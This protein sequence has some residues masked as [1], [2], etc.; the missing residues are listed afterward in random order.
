[1]KKYLLLVAAILA[2]F[3]SPAAAT[4]ISF[5]APSV[6]SGPFDVIVRAENLFAGRDITTDALLAFGFNVSVS[7]PSILSFTGA[8]SGPLFDPATSG[9]GTNV[10]ALA[11]GQN[12]IGI[13]PGATEPI[14]LATLHFNTIGIGAASIFITSDLGNVDQGL[15]FANAPFAESIAGT[16]PVTAAAATAVPEPATLLLSGIGLLG[17]STLRRIRR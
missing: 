6:V 2:T 9:P 16:V 4:T 11:F 12:G 17:L 13:E 7:D 1:M 10:L 5:T 3:G 14:L 15:Q 8:T